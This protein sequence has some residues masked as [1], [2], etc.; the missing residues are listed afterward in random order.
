MIDNSF[1]DKYNILKKFVMTRRT[2]AKDERLGLKSGTLKS[3][4]RQ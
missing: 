2:S 4:N 3:D 1:E